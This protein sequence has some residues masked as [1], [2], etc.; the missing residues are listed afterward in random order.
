[1]KK[2]LVKGM[3]FSMLAFAFVSCDSDDFEEPWV[4]P[5]VITT[6]VYILNSGQ[7]GK[8]NA[9]L[10]YYNPETNVLTG[11]IFQNQNDGLII[12]DTG[13]DMVIYGNKMYI[14]ASGSN[15]IYIT[16]LK[17]KLLK[18]SNGNDAIIEP[19]NASNQPQK[20]REGVAY[21]GKVY[22]SL[23]DGYVAQIDTT[24]MA[25]TKTVQVGTY[26]EQLTVTKNKLYVA[27]SG[28]GQGSTVS[29]VDLS[30]FT[31]KTI[32]VV[33][34]PNKI[35]TDKNNFVYIISWGDYQNTQAV[36]QKYDPSTGKLT[37]LGTKIASKMA[38]SKD[39]DKLF[40][41]CSTYDESWSPT[42]KLQSFNLTTNTLDEKSF[43]TVPANMDIS[44]AY[45]L[46]VDPINGDI[47]IGTSDY[48]TNGNMYI[49]SADGTY[50]TSFGTGGINPMGAYF[51]TGVK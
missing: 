5:E 32:D 28:Y 25:I 50:K 39:N 45:S 16:D 47:Y 34:N 19:L 18:Y 48:S 12:G 43:I 2:F 35:L 31:V 44:K 40:L 13:N 38:L 15:K 11:K 30:S 8:N 29:E 4:E 24:S 27:N 22:V 7:D 21:E 36:L 6:G 10:S 23:F 26:P 14:L 51:V 37:T 33:K 3:L 41:I 46:D 1:M 9:I 42:T 20:P 17:G 49:F